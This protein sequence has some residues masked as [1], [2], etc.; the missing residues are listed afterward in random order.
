MSDKTLIEQLNAAGISCRAL[1]SWCKCQEGR[2]DNC[3]TCFLESPEECDE[4][5]I[6]VLVQRLINEVGHVDEQL[7]LNKEWKGI[8]DRLCNKVM[9]RELEGECDG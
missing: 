1:A 3:E 8:V 4:K 5:V 2:K 9:D 6:N 7:K